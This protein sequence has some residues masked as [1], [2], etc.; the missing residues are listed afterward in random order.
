MRYAIAIWTVLIVASM[1]R[2]EPLSAGAA[3][4]DITPPTGFPM[5]GYA[6]R[7]DA[8][9]KG[10]R[11]PLS[12][13]AAVLAV[14]KTKLAFVSLDLGRAP[15]R[16]SMANIRKSLKDATQIETIFLVATHTHH[17]PVLELRD[18]PSKDKP[19]VRTLEEKIVKVIVDADKKLEPAKLGISAHEVPFNRNR[20]S[21]RADRP[22]DKEMII[23]RIDD[24]KGKPIAHLV[25]FAAHPTMLPW[26]L[27]EFSHDYPGFFAKHVETELGGLCLFL[28]GAEGDL[29]ANPQGAGGPE[30]FGETIGKFVVEKS[31]A[32]KCELAEPRKLQAKE[33]DF[34]FRA[35]I[36]ISNPLVYAAYAIA[37]FPGIVDHFEREYREGVRPHMTTALLDGRVGFVGV[38]GELFTSHAINLKRRARL[39]H[40]MVFGCCND[41]HQYFP[42]IEAVA[43]GG[44]GADTTVSPVEIG[45]GER[46]MDQ[47]LMDL[48][49]LQGKIRQ[50]R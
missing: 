30:K 34:K 6:A 22:V 46:M 43:E 37:F 45:A 23:I 21:K 32:I 24:A 35:R 39:E 25:N 50:M 1:S 4:I 31:R 47:A 17:G 26:K 10:V 44:Y 13:R 29:S 16:E 11:D 19:Y 8:P 38:S 49:E 40:L 48:L 33:R 28:Q 18:W 20:H 27:F 9:S 12:A 36:D 2:A 42:T 7:K 15:T 3:R 5:W 14:G 41:Y